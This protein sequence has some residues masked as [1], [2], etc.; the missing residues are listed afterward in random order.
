MNLK[1]KFIQISISRETHYTKIDY[2]VKTRMHIK[3]EPE[4]FRLSF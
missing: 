2:Y 3:L 4:I 1:L